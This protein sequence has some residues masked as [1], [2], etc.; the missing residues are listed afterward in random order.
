M[1]M[2]KP[3]EPAKIGSVDVEVFSR[4]LARMI[5][6]SG[7][8]L[9]AYLKPREEGK[10]KS[11]LSDDVGEVVRTVGQVAELLAVRPQARAR[12]A[13]Q[14]RPRLSRIV[15]RRGQAHGGR[16]ERAGRGYPTPRT[17]ASSI[18][19]GRRTSS[20]TS[21]SRPICSPP[22]GPTIWSRTPKASTSTPARRPSSTSS[23]SPPRSRRRISC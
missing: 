9:A 10:I 13:D 5:E 22:T 4:N 3:S 11:E 19:N 16:D 17:S 12:I 20:S 8:A 23:R 6:E 1:R 14:S 2:E 18:R 7:K 21:S 15:G